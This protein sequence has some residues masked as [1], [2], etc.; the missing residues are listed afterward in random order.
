MKTLYLVRHAKSSHDIPFLDD[1]MRGLSD[2][3]KA[4]AKLI[5]QYLN[6]TNAVISK[7]YSSHSVRTKATLAILNTYL[8]IQ[9]TAISYHEDLYTFDDNGEIFLQYGQKTDEG[10]DTILL[11]SH[12]YSCAQFAIRISKDRI[13]SYPTCSVL[14]CTWDVDSWSDVKMDNVTEV[15]MMTPKQLKG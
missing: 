9:D 14:K 2:R 12:N 15:S 4:D 3:G 11:L 6:E 1:V 10:L 8:H 7:I 13:I 5:G